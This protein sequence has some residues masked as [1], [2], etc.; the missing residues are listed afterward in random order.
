[1]V[2]MSRW[3]VATVALSLWHGWVPWGAAEVSAR[4]LE[5]SGAGTVEVAFVT[6]AVPGRHRNDF[7]GWVGMEFTVGATPLTVTALGRM[8][9]VGNGASHELRLVRVSDLTQV[10]GGTAVVSMAGAVPGQ[11]V[12]AALSQT[13]TLAAG[14]SYSPGQSRGIRGG[15]VA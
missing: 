7:A 8:C 1:M 4:P 13:V 10:A 11:F 3:W 14:S 2:R 12:Y 9:A 5:L 6:N 15:L